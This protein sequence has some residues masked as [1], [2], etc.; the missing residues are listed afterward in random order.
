MDTAGLWHTAFDDTNNTGKLLKK[1][2][3]KGWKPES[4]FDKI[5]EN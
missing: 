2:V 4:Y 5:R 1:L 3:E